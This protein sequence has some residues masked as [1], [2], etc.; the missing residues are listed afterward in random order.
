MID[1]GLNKSL[2]LHC[3]AAGSPSSG[4]TPLSSS[5]S[6]I[7]PVA[8]QTQ[9]QGLTTTA[10]ILATTASPPGQTIATQVQQV[11]VSV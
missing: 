2:C 3:F 1:P 7:Q 9:V 11:P 10:S 8:I 5:P 6:S 4:G